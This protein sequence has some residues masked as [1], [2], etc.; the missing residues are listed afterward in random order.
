MPTANAPASTSKRACSSAKS[1]SPTRRGRACSSRNARARARNAAVGSF[2]PSPSGTRGR[3]DRLQLDIVGQALGAELAPDAG[4]L[5][6]PERR[7]EVHRVLVH[8]VGPGADAPGNVEALVD[9]AS[10][11]RAGQ[12]VL[13][14]V[15]DAHSVFRVVVGD[16]REHGPEDLLLRNAHRVVDAGEHGW[17]HVP[18]LLEAG[19]T[20]IATHRDLGALLLTHRDVFLDPLL[21]ALGDH[22]ADFGRLVLWI[23]NGERADH[24][25]HRIDDLVVAVAAGEDARLRDARLTVVH[26]RRELEA[27]DRGGEVGVVEDDR[28]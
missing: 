20:A 25:R 18:A 3:H 24:A 27:L 2:R 11:H 9:V 5:V 28:G 23:T 13:A 8:A 14:V 6:A 26:E 17:L 12:A 4:P 7:H 15:G 10:P 1:S 22:W 19:R 16:D 21:L